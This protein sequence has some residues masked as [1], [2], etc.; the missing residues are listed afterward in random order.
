MRRQPPRRSRGG[1]IA[2]TV[3]ASLAAVLV[4]ALV[5]VGGRGTLPMGAAQGSA[6]A[7][8][9]TGGSA[10]TTEGSAV[11]TE[12]ADSTD[13]GSSGMVA[14]P[15]AFRAMIDA[16]Q[17]HS[18]RLIGD[19]ITAGYLCDGWADPD[20][21]KTTDV[22]YDN[23][24]GQI[25][26][27]PSPSI[28]CWANDF[29]V[30]AQGHGVSRFVNAGLGGWTM[31]MLSDYPS[32]GIGD[33]ADVI[34]VALG[35]NDAAY[36]GSEAL[37]QAAESALPVVAENCKLMV[38]VGPTDNERY[39]VSIADTVRDA[40]Q[41]LRE[42]CADHNY[43]YVDCYDCVTTDDLNDDLLHPTSEGSHK[44]WQ[45]ICTELSLEG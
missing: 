24:H 22:M 19:S 8:Q 17:V 10:S 4:F 36:D 42:V 43:I 25:H 32:F 15:G 27:E 34:F 13:E 16:G 37:R 26:Y 20:V 45:R 41:V 28:D 14:G 11:N 35:T 38:V 2:L 31:G 3:V 33:G 9:A 6:A 21:A 7:A 29:R 40:N 39:D 18:I 5:V 12:P 44:I 23:G 1:A 30:W